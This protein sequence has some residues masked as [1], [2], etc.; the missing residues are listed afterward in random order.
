MVDALSC[1]F[2]AFDA[3]IVDFVKWA[4][5]LGARGR[6]IDGPTEIDACLF[7][8]WEHAGPLVLDVRQDASVRIKGDG[9]LEAIRAMSMMH[10]PSA[11][12]CAACSEE[13]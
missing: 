8:D 12:M 10:V 5:A 3:P 9:R 4:E 11:R 1:G 6:R 13:G 2:C 7:D